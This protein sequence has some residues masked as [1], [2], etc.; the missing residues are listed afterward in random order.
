LKA[1]RRTVIGWL[2]AAAICPPRLEIPKTLKE[3]HAIRHAAAMEGAFLNYRE[4]ALQL[5]PDASPVFM[6]M[7]EKIKVSGVCELDEMSFEW[8]MPNER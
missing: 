2:L 8:R 4:L 7:L 5:Y 3:L 6:K 1:T